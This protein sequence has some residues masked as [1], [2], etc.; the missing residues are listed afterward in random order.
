MSKNFL[1]LQK[2]E[3]VRRAEWMAEQTNDMQ[4]I[5]A[6][7]SA[8]MGNIMLSEQQLAKMKRWQF[9]YDQFSTGKYTESD[10]RFQLAKMFNISDQVAVA[11]LRTAQEVFATTMALNKRFKI[12]LDIQ[13]I[14]VQQQKCRDTN[15]MDAY[16]KLQRVKNELYKMLPDEPEE[17]PADYFQPRTNEI[18]YDPSLLGHKPVPPEQMQALIDEMKREFNITD[19][20]YQV[21]EPNDPSNTL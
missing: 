15:N 5:K 8:R 19:I 13:L 17:T 10:I 16:A 2:A 14:D 1:A 20:D 6:Y 18:K 7:L 9:V 12:Q 11:D 4:M 21:I 3:I